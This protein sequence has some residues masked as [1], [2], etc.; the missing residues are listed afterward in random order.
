MRSTI[1]LQSCPVDTGRKLNVLR[2]SEDVQDVFW[3][4][5][6]RSIYV[7]YQR[8]TLFISPNI[9]AALIL[10]SF[11]KYISSNIMIQSSE[12]LFFSFKTFKALI[13]PTALSW[14]LF[15]N[16]ITGDGNV[17]SNSWYACN[18]DD[19]DELFL[20]YGWPKGV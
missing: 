1:S 16:D 14:I 10:C 13:A 9:F 18:D 17:L 3:T 7:L 2:R 6:V 19:D 4:S 12:I 8:R 11:C 15:N 20:W 5:Y